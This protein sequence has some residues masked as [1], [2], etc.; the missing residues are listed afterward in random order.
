[1]KVNVTEEGYIRLSDVYNPVVFEAGGTE[2]VAL[3]ERDGGIEVRFLRQDDCLQDDH[4]LFPLVHEAAGRFS[5]TGLFNSA[6]FAQ[7][8]HDRLGVPV[9]DGRTIALILDGR[10]GIRR[11]AGGSHWL[12]VGMV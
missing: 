5:S 3:C 8:L 11:L 9:L 4:F 6:T 10:E 1:M 2:R 12:I 7:V